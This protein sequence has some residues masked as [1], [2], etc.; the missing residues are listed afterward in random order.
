MEM[1]QRLIP[2]VAFPSMI[3][4]NRQLVTDEPVEVEE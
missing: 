3:G 4:G 2:E 1:S